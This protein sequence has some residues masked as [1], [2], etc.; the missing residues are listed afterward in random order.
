MSHPAEQI[1]EFIYAIIRYLR[2]NPGSLNGY[3]QRRIE[4]RA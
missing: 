3:V 1:R 2:A 4:N